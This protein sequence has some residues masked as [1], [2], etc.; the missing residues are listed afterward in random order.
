M[1]QIVLVYYS[2][3]CKITLQQ[4]YKDISKLKERF[5]LDIIK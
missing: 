5:Y 2:Y 3:I 4:H 1:A